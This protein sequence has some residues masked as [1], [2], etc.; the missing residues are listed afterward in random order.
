MTRPEPPPVGATITQRHN[1]PTNERDARVVAVLDDPDTG[2]F[3][4]VREEEPR[5]H[6]HVVGW[7]AFHVGLWKTK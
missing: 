7:T 5:P 3:C 2:W 6:H 1:H 4:V